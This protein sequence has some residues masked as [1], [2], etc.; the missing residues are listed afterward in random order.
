MCCDSFVHFLALV[1]GAYIVRHKEKVENVPLEI[2][3][4]TTRVRL[5]D[6]NVDAMFFLADQQHCLF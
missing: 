3:V 4:P 5:E 2:A 1:I 6:G